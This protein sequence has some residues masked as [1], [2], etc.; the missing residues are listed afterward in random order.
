MHG[1]QYPSLRQCGR[2]LTG[3]SLLYGLL[4]WPYVPAVAGDDLKLIPLAQE[5]R[6]EIAELMGSDIV[7]EALPAGPLLPAAAYLPKAP[8]LTF[9]VK[10]KGKKPYTETQH[11]IPV[12]QANSQAT[13]QYDKSGEGTMTFVPLGS[14]GLAVSQETD[15]EKEVVSTFTPPEPLIISG[16]APGQSEEQTISVSVAEIAK[17][18]KID[19]TGTLKVTYSYLGRFRIKIP[20]GTYEAD[21]LKWTYSG[22]VGPASIETAEYRF[23]AKDAGMVAMVQWRSISAMLI[24]HERSR[25]AR[26]LQSAGQ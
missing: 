19:Y 1:M 10:A 25:L 9:L 14:N 17:P 4:L 22:G 8:A 13:F 3:L 23:I 11:I 24:Y 18:A 2:K 12:S 21:L 7:L 20:A 5:D 16:L 26:Q 15:L 6:K